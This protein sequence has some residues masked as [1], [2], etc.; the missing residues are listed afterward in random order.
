MAYY[1][2]IECDAFDPF[3]HT[4]EQLRS[5]VNSGPF[6]SLVE[7]VNKWDI[8]TSLVK[9]IVIDEMPFQA[10]GD[11]FKATLAR[12]LHPGNY[13]SLYANEE[14]KEF[15]NVRHQK[16]IVNKDYKIAIFWEIVKHIV[17][18]SYGLVG[19]VIV[20]A[21]D[22]TEP[23]LLHNHLKWRVK[24]PKLA[25]ENLKDEFWQCFNN[26]PCIFHSDTMFPRS[27]PFFCGYFLCVG[28]AI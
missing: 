19:Q 28:C 25:P 9:I 16:G 15:N 18:T 7:P 14:E 17:D 13:N 21:N 6:E 8:D 23:N 22:V 5:D 4:E 27:F 20:F 24:T 2:E 10:F 1:T 11:L 3:Y 26:I 12:L